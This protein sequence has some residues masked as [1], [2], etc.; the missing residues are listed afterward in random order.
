MER[1]FF[2]SPQEAKDYGLIDS[3]ITNRDAVRSEAAA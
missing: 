2:L 3:V 1:D